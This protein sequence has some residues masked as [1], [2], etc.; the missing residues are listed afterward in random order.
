[1]ALDPLS[2]FRSKNQFSFESDDT[3]FPYSKTDGVP[4]GSRKFL[5]FNYSPNYYRKKIGQD[6]SLAFIRGGNIPSDMQTTIQISSPNEE[7]EAPTVISCDLNSSTATRLGVIQ[8]NAISPSAVINISPNVITQYPQVC[9][10]EIPEQEEILYERAKQQKPNFLYLPAYQSSCS[11]HFRARGYAHEDNY[12]CLRK[13]IGQ[14]GAPIIYK[15]RS[16]CCDDM[17]QCFGRSDGNGVNAFLL[18]P[19]YPPSDPPTYTTVSANARGICCADPPLYLF[20]GN[21]FTEECAGTRDQRRCKYGWYVDLTSSSAKSKACPPLAKG[22]IN[23]FPMQGAITFIY[24][25]GGNTNCGCN[26]GIKGKISIGGATKCTACSYQGVLPNGNYTGIYEKKCESVS[27]SI[28]QVCACSFNE[29][30][31]AGGDTIYLTTYSKYTPQFPNG[32]QLILTDGGSIEAAG[33]SNPV[34]GCDE[35]S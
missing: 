35:F 1:M 30:I 15:G 14:G 22:G 21:D 9:E 32:Q 8:N 12:T 34:L 6:S 2:Y 33:C 17:C 3:Q 4:V 19:D 29:Q 13:P 24:Q 27:V 20:G 16:Y 18:V 25:G 23:Y 7:G 11:D 10:Q 5:I 28:P 31:S 26:G